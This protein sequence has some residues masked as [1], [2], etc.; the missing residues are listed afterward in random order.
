MANKKITT[1]LKYV[2]TASPLH[3]YYETLE[4]GTNVLRH[5]RV[6][7]RTYQVPA[8]GITIDVVPE[9]SVGSK[10]IENESVMLEDLNEEVTDRL[11]NVYD[12][13]TERLFING[14][15]PKE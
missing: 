3:L 5:I 2:Y 7:Q 4:D 15:K 1:Q 12:E 8:D 10:Q 13:N 9:N 11:T 14:A 6:N